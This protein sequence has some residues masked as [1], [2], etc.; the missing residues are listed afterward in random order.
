[1]YLS[2]LCNRIAGACLRCHAYLVT[3]LADFSVAIKEKKRK[4]NT[5]LLNESVTRGIVDSL[6]SLDLSY[7]ALDDVPFKVFR[8]LR[9]LNWLNMH[10]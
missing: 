4:R 1:M 3:H 6:R 7:N 5:H 10:R 9:K 8:D 2:H